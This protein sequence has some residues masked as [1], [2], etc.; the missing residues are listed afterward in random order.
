MTL[1]AF[2]L[3]ALSGC[4]TSNRID[5]PPCFPFICQPSP[6]APSVSTDPATNITANGADL[7]GHVNPNWKDTGGW[8]EWSTLATMSS[9][10]T[11]N[12][13]QF[14][15]SGNTTFTISYPVSGLAGSTTYY[16]RTVAY[17]TL[18]T[19]KGNIM[20]FTTP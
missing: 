11:N 20:S 10:S 9:Y 8:F 15:G 4:G 19:S 12:P 13:G 3:L 16:H 1:L 17:N 14:L 18:G 5:L 6:A 2:T 7:N